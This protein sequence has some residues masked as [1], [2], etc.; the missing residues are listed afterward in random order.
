M[1]AVAA[2]QFAAVSA[3]GWLH[4]KCCDIPEH[5]PNDGKCVE[6]R[7]TC[8]ETICMKCGG[9]GMRKC[10][11]A[12]LNCLTTVLLGPV[13]AAQRLGTPQCIASL[14]YLLTIR[15]GCLG[16]ADSDI[17]Q[18]WSIRKITMSPM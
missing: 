5:Y 13:A 10:P 8:W 15:K 16:D 4:E 7:T 9:D 12:L 1:L 11:S 14:L 17:P 3:C 18:W 6:Y 2:S